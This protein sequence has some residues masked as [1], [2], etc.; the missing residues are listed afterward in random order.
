MRLLSML[1]AMILLFSSCSLRY[2]A[3]SAEDAKKF[4]DRNRDSIEIIVDYLAELESDLAFIDKDDETIFYDFERHEIPSEEVKTCI[5]RLWRS[6]CIHISKQNVQ[7]T[8][9][10]SFEIWHRTM[11]DADCGIACTISG[12]GKP[13]TEFQISCESI[14]ETWFYYYD[15]YEEYRQNPARYE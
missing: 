12:Q 13:Y 8:D 3:P 4:L 9:T 2:T 6:G 15:N 5:D 7:E 1:S 14:D 10:I 11:G